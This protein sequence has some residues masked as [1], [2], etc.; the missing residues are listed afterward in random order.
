MFNR[1]APASSLTWDFDLIGA[2]STYNGDSWWKYEVNAE[3]AANGYVYEKAQ[4]WDETGKLV[5]VSRETV[6]IYL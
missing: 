2:E 4:L 1:P 6:A 3:Y 5:A